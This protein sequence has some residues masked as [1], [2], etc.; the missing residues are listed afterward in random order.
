MHA[1][2]S[3]TFMVTNIYFMFANELFF[4]DFFVEPDQPKMFFFLHIVH[5]AED[6]YVYFVEG[7]REASKFV[8]SIFGF[9]LLWSFQ[10][11]E[12]QISNS[13]LENLH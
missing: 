2:N 7:N 9:C 5:F 8:S 11:V 1:Y 6:D 3:F 12:P 13:G 10:K 4:W